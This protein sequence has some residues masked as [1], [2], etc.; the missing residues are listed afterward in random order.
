MNSTAK[1]SL[2][3][4][5]SQE[6]LMFA[7]NSCAEI[8]LRRGRGVVCLGASVMT[9]APDLSA[10]HPSNPICNSGTQDPQRR[11]DGRRILGITALECKSRLLCR[12]AADTQNAKPQ[13]PMASD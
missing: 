12:T 13:C 5:K 6:L 4:W 2:S 9:S 8:E 1:P 3:V 10:C 7:T 11:L